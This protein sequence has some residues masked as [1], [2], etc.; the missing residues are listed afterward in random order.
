V[1]IVAVEWETWE[2]AYLAVT[3]ADAAFIAHART[4]VEALAAEVRRMREQLARARYEAFAD[5]AKIADGVA[6]KQWDWGSDECQHGR[7]HAAELI[8]DTIRER[9]ER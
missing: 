6:E 8:A 7:V 9:A 1:D 4:D 2:D 5:C 3:D